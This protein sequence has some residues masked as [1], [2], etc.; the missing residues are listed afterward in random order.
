MADEYTFAST[1]E[2]LKM[3]AGQSV[4]RTGCV[5]V[6]DIEATSTVWLTHVLSIVFLGQQQCYSSVQTDDIFQAL[7]TRTIQ[8]TFAFELFH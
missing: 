6:H 5:C 2:N 4:C 7:A 1:D 8:S 3:A